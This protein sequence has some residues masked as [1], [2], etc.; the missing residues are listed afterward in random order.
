M[1]LV[2]NNKKYVVISLHGKESIFVFPKEIDHD[3]FVE[4]LQAIRFGATHRW[5]RKYRDG[6]VVSAGFVENGECVGHSVTLDKS[7]RPDLDT[8]LLRG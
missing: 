1:G 2:M 5:E 8:A 3:R 6:D 4:G 7:S